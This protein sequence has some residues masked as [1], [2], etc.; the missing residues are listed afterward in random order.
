VTRPVQ[1]LAESAGKVARRGIG[2]PLVENNFERRKSDNWR[3]A[4]HQS[5]ERMNWWRSGNAWCRPSA[6]PPGRELARPASPT[7]LKNPLFPLQI[8][9]E[10]M[11]RRP[12]E[13]YPPSSS[14]R[15][16]SAKGPLPPRPSPGTCVTNASSSMNVFALLNSMVN[17]GTLSPRF[18]WAILWAFQSSDR[19]RTQVHSSEFR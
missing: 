1:R 5:H 7:N 2:Q 13:R 3:R 18:L 12:R 10:N 11:Q 4:F 19:T 16:F 15:F 8:T 17:A 6:W 9:V 14:T